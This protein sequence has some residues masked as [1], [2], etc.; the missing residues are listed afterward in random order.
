MGNLACCTDDEM[1]NTA[2]GGKPI[3]PL[4]MKIA[5]NDGKEY[6]TE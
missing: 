2:P 3:I 1:Y 6:S 4:D 5:R